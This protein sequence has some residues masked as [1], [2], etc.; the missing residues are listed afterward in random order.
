MGF[1]SRFTG[2]DIVDLGEGYSIT[3]LRHLPG[4]AQEQAEAAKVKAVA[5]VHTED[6][7]KQRTVE[8]ATSTDIALYTT[9][10]LDAA[11]VS[12]NLTDERDQIMPLAPLD[13]RLASIRRLPAGVRTR[14]R[15]HIEKNIE[16]G[17]PSAEDQQ[18]FR[19]E[20]DGRGADGEGRPG[21]PAGVPVPGSVLDQ[22]RG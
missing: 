4:D 14:L 17:K 22:V 5:N 11:V 15:E 20:G 12:W 8:V 16:A 18:S 1:L 21:G 7:D 3:L 19:G 9:L 13:A 6:G 10:L 2:T